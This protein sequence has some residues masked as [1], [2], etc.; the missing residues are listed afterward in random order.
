MET[1]ADRKTGR[2]LT[3]DRLLIAAFVLLLR[4]PFLNQAIQGDDV[5][6]LGGAQ[7]A[8]IN[9]AHPNHY[10]YV[11]LGDRVDMRGHPHPPWNVWFLGALLAVT[12]DIREPVFHA[13]YIAFSLIAAFSVYALARRFSPRPLWAT[14]LFLVTPAFVIN[15]N[16]LESDVPF[17]AFWLAGI[18]LVVAGSR[19]APLPLALAAL[20]AFQS[21]LLTP[22]L[23]LYAWLFARRSRRLWVLALV[24]PLTLAAWLLWERLSTGAFPLA[25]LSG[26][27]SRYGFQ[28]LSNK[29]GNALMLTIHLAWI[30]FPAL[31]PGAI[32]IAWRKRDR[33]TVF[34]AGW[35]AIFFGGAL[36]IFFA[37]SARYL[38]PVAAPLALLASRLSRGWLLAAFAIYLPLGVA[39]SKVNYDHWNGYREF[40]A[41]IRDQ[42]RSRR[43]WI[44]AEWGL[45]YYLETDGALPLER[46]QG[47]RPGEL[48][49]TSEL[50]YPV[51]FTT[52]GG[53][54]TPVAARTITS[55]IPLRLIGLEARSG[56]STFTK[57]FLPFA[58]TTS[59]IDRVRAELV[60]ERKPSLSYLPMN[61]PEAAHQIVSGLYSVEDNRWRWMADRAVMLLKAPAQSSALEAAFAIPDAAPARTVTLLLDGRVVASQTYAQPGAYTLKSP[62]VQPVG[63]AATLTITV[64]K[65]F[66]VPGD[67]RV[68]G[69]IL[70][71]AG[72]R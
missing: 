52:G 3:R 14:L 36:A 28:A 19:W 71:G 54:L 9:P 15:G 72:F 47:V 61:A 1:A 33:E 65:T 49:V 43:A 13:A 12:G 30:V 68:L 25:V 31:L 27:F 21:V 16:S 2:R 37:G 4:L 41:Q 6:Y 24:P 40:A 56:Y 20:A 35:I 50:A 44:D 60:I 57:G 69:V 32:W 64:D 34:L 10:Q 22:I 66:S 55:A 5:Y 18:A 62:P 29:A 53:A 39:L 38:L 67:R 46:G 51:A 8:Q 42:V 7:N 70:T 26:H 63:P 23:W 59:P 45:R 11:F 58:I 48:V 17:V